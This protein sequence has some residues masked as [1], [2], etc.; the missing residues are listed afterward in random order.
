MST[1]R[2]DKTIDELF[3]EFLAAQKARFSPQVYGRY[4]DIIERQ[5]IPG[6]LLAR[7][8]R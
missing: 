5:G 3:A 4:E 8:L 2:P 7:P 1:L 6:A